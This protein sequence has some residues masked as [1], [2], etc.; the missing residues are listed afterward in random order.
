MCQNAVKCPW[1]KYILLPEG[2]TVS[3][4]TD[5]ICPSACP[6]Y[7]SRKQCCLY[8]IFTA[9]KGSEVLQNADAEKYEYSAEE[10]KRQ[11]PD[12]D[13]TTEESVESPTVEVK[14]EEKAYELSTQEASGG[15]VL[16]IF[17]SEAKSDDAQGAVVSPMQN[18]RNGSPVLKLAPTRQ[19]ESFELRGV[20]Y[21]LDGRGG[22]KNLNDPVCRNAFYRLIL[23]TF[24]VEAV[25][26][27]DG[28][29]DRFVW[30]MRN[31]LVEEKLNRVLRVMQEDVDLNVKFFLLFYYAIFFDKKIPL[32]WAKGFTPKLQP[33]YNDVADFY[34]KIADDRDFGFYNKHAEL[35][36]LWL[37]TIQIDDLDDADKINGAILKIQENVAVDRNSDDVVFFSP[38]KGKFVR[39]GRKK[40]FVDKL[41]ISDKTPEE[42][43]NTAEFLSKYDIL[44]QGGQYRVEKRLTQEDVFVTVGESEINDDITE[45]LFSQDRSLTKLES[46]LYVVKRYCELFN[47]RSVRVGKLTFS[48]GRYTEQTEELVF[49][50]CAYVLGNAASEAQKRA[51]HSEALL[52]KVLYDHSI[53]FGQSAREA[54]SETYM[55]GILSIVSIE[56]SEA[57]LARKFFEICRQNGVDDK[58]KLYSYDYATIPRSQ[59]MFALREWMCRTVSGATGT[60]DLISK[61]QSPIFKAYKEVIGNA[62]KY[63]NAARELFGR[64]QR[65]EQ[66]VLDISNRV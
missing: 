15:Y 43:E 9:K 51:K 23:N 14:A 38:S 57:R 65:Q 1:R 53:L 36:L 66:N 24:D 26:D 6:D 61:L 46:Y 64:Y 25:F 17:G 21:T 7:K 4:G 16:P 27:D 49:E 12:V 50:M 8:S 30:V 22:T 47:P 5:C 40:D 28:L 48:E 34:R 13:F 10:L 11:F 55:N 33:I 20:Y 32:Y 19:Y 60:S 31:T 62:D 35:A 44:L 37:R 2:I 29:K 52:A 59:R 58:I 3:S 42:L 54:R 63:A 45:T 18:V 39:L 41:C 56:Q